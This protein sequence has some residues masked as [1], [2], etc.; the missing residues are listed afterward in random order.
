MNATRLHDLYDLRNPI[1]S[2]AKRRA[3]CVSWTPRQPS[4]A[5]AGASMDGSATPC[6]GA[7]SLDLDQAVLEHREARA[8]AAAA[9]ALWRQGLAGG[10]DGAPADASAG[11]EHS[12]DDPGPEVRFARWLVEAARLAPSLAA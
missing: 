12:V 4:S 8:T 9:R 7:R 6:W 2:A 5:P 3:R 1:A 10:R 11:P